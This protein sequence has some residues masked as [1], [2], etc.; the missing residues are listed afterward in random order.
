MLQPPTCCN[1]YVATNILQPTYQHAA[2]NMFPVAVV[3][4]VIVVLA[5]VVNVVDDE[6][7]VVIVIFHCCFSFFCVNAF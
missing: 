3:V 4:F 6:I 1:Q 7:V 5:V 2:T